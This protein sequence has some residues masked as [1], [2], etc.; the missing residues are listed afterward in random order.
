MNSLDKDHYLP[1]FINFS[2]R[3]SA[4]QTQVTATVNFLIQSSLIRSNSYA[5]S[6]VNIN[7]A[8]IFCFLSRTILCPGWIREERGYLALPWERNALFLWMI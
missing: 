4:N 3:T 5:D 2:A 7:G 1:F 8:L 6:H